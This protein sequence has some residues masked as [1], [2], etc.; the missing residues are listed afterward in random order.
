MKRL[1]ISQ[2]RS[3]IKRELG[4]SAATLTAPPEMN[5]NPNYPWYTMSAGTQRIDAYPQEINQG[6]YTDTMIALSVTHENSNNGTT[7]YFFGDSLEYAERYTEWQNREAFC[8][9]M[10]DS[11]DD[12]SLHRLKREAQD[13]SWNHFHR[14]RTFTPVGL[15]KGTMTRI[16]SVLAVYD[17]Y[18]AFFEINPEFKDLKP[19]YVPREL[20]QL[21]S[22]LR[23]VGQG[24]VGRDDT[25]FVLQD[26]K[27]SHVYLYDAKSKIYL[28]TPKSTEEQAISEEGPEMEM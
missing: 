5:G 14:K 17:S 24:N 12:P 8:E 19:F 9:S 10:E 13:E 2:A 27:N 3:L 4:L 11:E 23:F 15:E 25:A 28:I 22:Q 1:S 16:E 26:P 7:E 6:K 18:S 21:D 20:P